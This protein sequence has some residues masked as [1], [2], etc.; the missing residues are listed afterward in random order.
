MPYDGGYFHQYL[1]H[2]AEE[3]LRG[4]EDHSLLALFKSKGELNEKF[5]VELAHKKK[6][7][8]EGQSRPKRKRFLFFEFEKKLE[9]NITQIKTHR[10]IKDQKVM[11]P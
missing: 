2:A 3:D 11:P 10:N 5:P 4:K 8:E 7:E 1:A 6:F 9:R